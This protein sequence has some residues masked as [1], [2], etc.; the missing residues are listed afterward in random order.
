MPTTTILIDKPRRWD[1]PFGAGMSDR[2][3][4]EIMSTPMFRDIDPDRFPARLPLRGIIRNDTRIASYEP[5]D[6]IV[7][8]GDYGSSAFLILDGTVL[9]DAGAEDPVSG[10]SAREKEGST[11]RGFFYAIPQ[12]WRNLKWPEARR[13]GTSPTELDAARHLEPGLSARRINDDDVRIFFADLNDFRNQSTDLRI[14]REGTAFGEVAA[15]GRTPRTA[16]VVA[17]TR[18]RLLEIRWQGLR[19]LRKYAAPIRDYIDRRYRETSLEVHLSEAK[20]FQHLDRELLE[21]VKDATE[22][23]THGNFDWYGS[24]KRL[25]G[26]DALG[27]LREEPVIAR[28]G[29]YPNGIILIRSG[30]ARLSH[31]FGH[32]ELTLGYLGKGQT[33]GLAEIAYNRRN[34]AAIPLQNTLRSIGYVDALFVPTRIIEDYVLP[35]LP[36]HL[37]PEL[38]R[39]DRHLSSRSPDHS[40]IDA[41]DIEFLVENRIVNGTA[42]MLIDLDRCTRCDDCVR[43]CSSTHDDNPRFLRSGPEFSHFMVA[44]AC[45]HCT[46]PVCLIGCPTGA[47]SR[48]PV[49]GEVTINDSTCI[50]CATCYNN[51]PY[52]AIRMVQIRGTDGGLILDEENNLPIRKATKCDLCFEQPGG[53]ACERACPHDAL[54]RM[55]M[56]DVETLGKWLNR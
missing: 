53:P 32:G 27:R 6:V 8:R 38:D 10:D 11:G 3:F 16:T 1:Q 28:E 46:D 50:G 22:F 33:Y 49:G 25:T 5:G 7:R 12:L 30:F 52:D 14:Y 45:M 24:Y 26:Q 35:D 29:D 40:K 20:I 2:D 56:S 23:E 51:C 13:I 31:I 44:N 55:D 17:E 15:L 34:N 48:N 21:K 54:V 18:T 36:E 41:A 37:L 9:V 4:D 19:E 47:I 39:N 43:A 42:T